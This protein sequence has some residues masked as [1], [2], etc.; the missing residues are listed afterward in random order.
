MRRY[1]ALALALAFAP[2]LSWCA[3]AAPSVVAPPPSRVFHGA[4]AA[5]VH[6]YDVVA[7]FVDG[8]PVEGDARFAFVWR[9]ANW[10]FASAEHRD[11]FAK[12][13][14]RYAP[15]YGGYCAFGMSRGYKAPTEPD[16]WTVIDGKLY[17]NYNREVQ[18]K[19]A[20]NRSDFITKADAN[21]PRV[22]DDPPV[23]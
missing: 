15:Q 14:E 7:Y 18:K 23:E 19:W 2:A 4:D 5:A 9:E 10:R 12:E 17:L 21:W 11:A 6:G 22:Q 8:R 20:E 13:P 3:C 1:V 16:A